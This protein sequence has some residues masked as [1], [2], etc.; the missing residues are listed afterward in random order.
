MV[1]NTKNHALKKTRLFHLLALLF[2]SLFAFWTLQCEKTATEN[3]QILSIE[4]LLVDNNEFTGWSYDGAS[5]LASNI[6]ELTTYINGAAEIYQRHGFVEA[7]HQTYRGKIDNADRQLKLTIY[8][9]GNESQAKDT[10]DDPDIGLVG[11]IDWIDGAGQEA[12]YIRYSGLSQALTFY[13]S[14]YFVHLEISYDTEE[15]LN[16]LK[17]FAWNIDGKIE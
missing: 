10:Y 9:Q 1:L 4:D 2:V 8:N 5:W 15:S 14:R 7:T 3:N 17:Q 6:S 16:I 11:A 13:R 12:H